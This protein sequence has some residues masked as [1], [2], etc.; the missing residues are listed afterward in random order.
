MTKKFTH[1]ARTLVGTLKPSD[2]KT[3][4]EATVIVSV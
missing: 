2:V 1:R 3:Q 4:Y